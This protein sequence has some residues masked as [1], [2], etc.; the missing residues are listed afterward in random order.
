MEVRFCS[1]ETKYVPKKKE[2]EA[3]GTSASEGGGGLQ[4]GGNSEEKGD[5]LDL[6]SRTQEKD[7]PL[8]E[9]TIKMEMGHTL[10]NSRNLSQQTK[11]KGGF[12]K[13]LFPQGGKTKREKGLPILSDHLFLRERSTGEKFP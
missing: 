4:E 11:K 9:E 1:K 6:S 3:R 5:E 12:L 7:F 8:R 2:K 13:V 10:A